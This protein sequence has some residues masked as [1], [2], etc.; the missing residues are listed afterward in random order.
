MK[1]PTDEEI[2][3]QIDACENSDCSGM[4][5]ED[6]VKAALEWALGLNNDTPVE[7]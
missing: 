1:K 3:A 2:Y 4:S 5:Y 6:G 7:E